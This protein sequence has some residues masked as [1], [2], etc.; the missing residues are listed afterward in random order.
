M[1]AALEVDISTSDIDTMYKRRD[2][3]A[4]ISDKMRR[5]KQDKKKGRQSN[6]NLE[7][8]YIKKTRHQSLPML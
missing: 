8:K 6:A 1:K 2:I 7:I 5:Y 3:D 4:E